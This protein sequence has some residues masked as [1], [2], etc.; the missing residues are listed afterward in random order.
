VGWGAVTEKGN[1]KTCDYSHDKPPPLPSLKS[2]ILM[3]FLTR[4]IFQNVIREGVELTGIN[5]MKY[6]A[7]LSWSVFVQADPIFVIQKVPK[8][9]LLRVVL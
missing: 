5:L 8:L 2:H 3:S 7:K 9:C 4:K 1:C 6:S